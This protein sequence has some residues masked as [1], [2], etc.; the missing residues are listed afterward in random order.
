VSRRK[1]NSIE[2]QRRCSSV[3]FRLVLSKGKESV[4]YLYEH[5]AISD[6]GSLGR[7]ELELQSVEGETL[8]V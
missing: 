5:L 1:P 6:E 7:D 4:T 2:E 3:Q 8:I